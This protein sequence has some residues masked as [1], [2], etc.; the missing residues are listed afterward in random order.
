VKCE[1]VRIVPTC[2]GKLRIGHVSRA[3]FASAKF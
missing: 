3:K 2:N 1:R